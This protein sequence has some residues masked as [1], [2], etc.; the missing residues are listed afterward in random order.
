[1]RFMIIVVARNRIG[2]VQGQNQN[3]VAFVA[4]PRIDCVKSEQLLF[5]NRRNSETVNPIYTILKHFQCTIY[6]IYTRTHV[7]AR[8][9][10]CSYV[11]M[12]VKTECGMCAAK[13]LR[14]E[15]WHEWIQ[16]CFV[17]IVK[18]SKVSVFLCEYCYLR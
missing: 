1:M 11:R 9:C 13:C 4:F 15:S 3:R 17:F 5:M 14:V 12:C 10:A 8:V 7:C 2:C 16:R 6:N 18:L